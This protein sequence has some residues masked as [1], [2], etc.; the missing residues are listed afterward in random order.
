KRASV[1]TSSDRASAPPQSSSQSAQV[2]TNAAQDSRISATT[3][4]VS[5]REEDDGGERNLTTA[6]KSHAERTHR[7][8]GGARP[9][10]AKFGGDTRTTASLP[11]TA[12]SRPLNAS[13]GDEA[14]EITTDFIPLVH[15]QLAPAGSGHLV[16]VELP[17]AALARFGLP[18][19]A[20][21][22][23]ERVKADVLMGDDGIARAIRFV[24]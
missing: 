7:R 22:A 11:T 21:R 12:A 20:E 1:V 23:G 19:N 17:R 24:R 2:E 14:D 18:L 13:A 9:V 15:D 10:E 16:R 4:E 6:A 8:A 3:D 5:V